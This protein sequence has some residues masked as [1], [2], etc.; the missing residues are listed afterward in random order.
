M[1]HIKT[2]TVPCGNHLISSDII[3]LLTN[4]SLDA[5]IDIVLN[6]IYDNRKINT[7][8]N[9]R[10][11]KKLIKLFTKDVHFNFNGNTYAQ[12]DGVAMESTLAPLL[13]GGFMVQLERTVIPKLYQ[14]FNFGNVMSL[15]LSVLLVMNTKNLF[16]HVSIVFTI[17]KYKIGK[18]MKYPFLTS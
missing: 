17:H 2:K 9:K 18:E 16:C 11:M 1:E 7:T 8:I 5:T 6:H 3:V 13:E 15:T 12:K 4:V 14:Y 10:E